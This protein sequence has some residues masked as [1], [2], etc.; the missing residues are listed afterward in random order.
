MKR[1]LLSLALL[2]SLS[3]VAQALTLDELYDRLKKEPNAEKLNLG[4]FSMFF[5]NMFSGGKDT[6]MKKLHSVTIQDCTAEQVAM[7]EQCLTQV[8]ESEYE[9]LATTNAEDEIIRILV[10]GGDT[11]F[12]EVVVV[13]WEDD[14]LN[15]V[16]MWGKIDPKDIVVSKKD[17]VKIPITL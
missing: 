13:L 17:D 4:T 3:S 7:V 10:K 11:Y 16:R 2:L 1:I 15:Y 9:P 5:L 6:K 8:D 14:E 12:E